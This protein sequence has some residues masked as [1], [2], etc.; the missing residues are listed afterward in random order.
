MRAMLCAGALALLLSL[1]F[2][3]ASY[4]SIIEPYNATVRENGSIYLGKV[5]P[6][7]T[8]YVTI[9]AATTNA[10]GSMLNLGWNRLVANG[11]PQGWLAQN[12]SLYN[13]VL[14]TKIT[15]S[16]DAGNGT[17]VFG[18]TAIN[19]G[20]YSKIGSVGFRAYVNVTPDVFRLE[21]H[22]AQISAA[23]GA[24][25]RIY[26]QIN[27]T[28]VSDS[29]FVISAQ[30]LPG[31]SLNQ[32]VIALHRTAQQFVYSVYESEPGVYDLRLRVSSLS[33]PRVFK[34]TNV[35]LR[36]GAGL[37]N[38]YEA[39]GQGAIAFPVIYEPAYAVMY[40]LSLLRHAYAPSS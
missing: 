34:E 7:Q 35:T 22:P 32:T 15:V 9:S 2:A 13:P 25:A 30:D 36:V 24:P 28:G 38:D 14:S 20:N 19:V 29:P 1:A 37:L 33:S 5:G 26:V 18:L 40:L 27:N 6:G 23:P 17:Y 16:P 8:F 31:A 12:S 11:I 4:V 39:L 10:T 3:Q 21:V